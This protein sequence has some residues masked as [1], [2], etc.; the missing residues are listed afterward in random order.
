MTAASSKNV[1]KECFAPCCRDLAIMITKP[2]TKAEVQEL[3]WQ[4]Q[5]DT[6]KV[7]VRDYHWSLL[8]KGKCMYLNRNNLCR[9]YAQRPSTCR[10]HRPPECERYGKWYDALITTPDELDSYLIKKKKK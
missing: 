2:R 10:R 7:Y 5:F 9:V 4:L 3:K 6:V 1:C 8:V